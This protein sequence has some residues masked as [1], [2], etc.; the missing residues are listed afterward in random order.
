MDVY[1]ILSYKNFEKI[2]IYNSTDWKIVFKIS[3]DSFLFTLHT[4]TYYIYQKNFDYYY[5]SSL[6]KNIKEI[7]D[8]I[9]NL[10]KK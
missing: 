6:K 1:N 7:I 10:I 9:F 8:M 4:I 2:F 5:L 3:I